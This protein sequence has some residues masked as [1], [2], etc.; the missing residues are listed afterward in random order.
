M[1]FRVTILSAADEDVRQTVSWIHQRSPAR[2]EAW[3]RRWIA[4]LDCLETHAA[5]CGLAPEDE[6]HPVDIR[7]VIFKTRRGRPYRAIFTII[8]DEVFV[9]RIR[10]PGQDVVPPDELNPLGVP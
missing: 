2:A 9:L 5:G 3:H 8:D 4:I 7:H 6:L 10:G 1:T